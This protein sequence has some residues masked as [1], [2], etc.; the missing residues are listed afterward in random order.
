MTKLRH[1]HIVQFLGI[2]FDPGTHL[3]ALV[4]EYLPST[5]AQ[6]VESYGRLPAEI[7]Y[8]ILRDVALGLR[9][10]HEHRPCVIHRDLSANN[11][12]HS[13]YGGEDLRYGRR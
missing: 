12:L 7:C 1:P 8:A 11:V 10:L 4:M 3:P 9:Y 13:R 2:Y 6:C 5:L